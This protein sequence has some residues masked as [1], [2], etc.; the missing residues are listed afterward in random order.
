M[1][2]FLRG[3]GTVLGLELQQ[4]VRTRAWYILLGVFFVVVGFVTLLLT[5]ALGAFGADTAGAGILSTI[6]YFVLLLGTLVT[7]AL[8]GNAINGDRAEG[9]LATTQVTQ[10]GTWQLVLGKF[11]AAWIGAL[12]FLAVSLPFIALCTVLGGVRVDTALVSLLVLIF[13]LGVVAAVGVGLSGLL[14]RPLFSI[15]VTYLVVAALS[16]GTL[17]VFTLAGIAT[18]STVTTTSRYPDYSQADPITGEFDEASCSEWETTTYPTP[19]FDPYWGVLAANPY[20]LLADATPTHFD[21]NGNPDDLFGFVKTGIRQA[22]IPPELEQTYDGCSNEFTDFD[23]PEE[24]I[25]KTV[26]GWFVGA[27]I[28]LV[29]AGG[30]L[31]AGWSATR[32]PAKRLAKGSRVA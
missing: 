29:L 16:I 21:A 13:E 4:R 23:T 18:Q 26:P 20:V 12:A 15:V 30:L 2:A 9:T 3:I 19:R 27:L 10:I 17:I 14:A 31:T 24:I 22:Q 25:A 5:V 28:H 7:P 6:I 1:S 32:T 8:S 11:L